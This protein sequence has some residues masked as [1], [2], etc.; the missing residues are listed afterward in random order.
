MTSTE[1]EEYISA[2]P[3]AELHLHIE[4]SLEPEM[5]FEMAARNRVRLK[6]ASVEALK[7]AYA[8]GNLQHF[9]DIYYAGA[10]ALRREQDFYELTMA[11]LRKAHADR[12]LHT[13]IFFDPQ[14]HT[15]RGIPFDSVVRGILDA[16]ADGEKELGISSRLILCFL[17]HLGEESAF[18]ALQLAL[19]YRDHIVAVGLDSSER[20]FPPSLFRRVFDKAR[21]E[22]F[23]TVAHAGEEGPAAYVRE[24][25][26]LLL[27]RRIDHGYAAIDDADLLERLAAEQITLTMCPL[28]N[29]RLQVYPD[30][31]LHPLK[32]MLDRGI[33]VTVN[34]D[35]PAYFGGY[36]NDNFLA[37][38]RALNLSRSDLRLLAV[39]SFTGSFL[40]QERKAELIA[41]IP[42]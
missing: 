25:L 13:E 5:L 34:S 31:T 19:P 24:A 22:G 7:R 23:L 4:G 42:A 40:D 28:S 14:T 17:R 20:G 26:D 1:L 18:E 41:T 33:P 12:V 38:S 2:L 30:L 21:E 39:H 32:E 29:Q 36:V 10:D 11:Y 9:L 15:A 35:D 3:K 37:I 27:V 16:L 6:Y 8:F